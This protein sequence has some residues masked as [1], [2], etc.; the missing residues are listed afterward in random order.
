MQIS[1]SAL[2]LIIK[3]IL[4]EEKLNQQL[5]QEAGILDTTFSMMKNAVKDLESVFTTN[6]E[7]KAGEILAWGGTKATVTTLCPPV[8]EPLSKNY[9]VLCVWDSNDKPKD[10]IKGDMKKDAWRTDR[11]GL[12]HKGGHSV[13]HKKI[14]LSKKWLPA[15][16]NKKVTDKRIKKLEKKWDDGQIAAVK[17]TFLQSEREFIKDTYKGGSITDLILD[18]GP[19]VIAG[20]AE[21]LTLIPFPATQ[22][23]FK[24]VSDTANMMDAFRKLSMKDFLGCGLALMG[25]VPIVGDSI[26]II[27]NGVKKLG[28]KAA[29]SVLN[30]RVLKELI[31]ILGKIID[32]DLVDTFKE[33]VSSFA[34]MRNVDNKKLFPNIKASLITFKASL[35]R[36]LGKEKEFKAAVAHASGLAR[37]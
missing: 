27:G 28:T 6:K 8:Y 31:E 37:K 15:A 5:Q 3:K 7:I 18:T 10:R 25:L 1:E 30:Q 35:E 11:F 12:F 16:G 24:G 17:T 29:A 26:G 32:G 4:V 22:V 34:T 36:S 9:Y 13:D 33:I 21:L 2:R 23:L 14:I 19:P 20:V